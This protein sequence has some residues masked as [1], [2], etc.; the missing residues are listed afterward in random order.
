MTD[1]IFFIDANWN[2]TNVTNQYVFTGTD[3]SN[4]DDGRIG[5]SLAARNRG[6][7]IVLN[8]MVR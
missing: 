5:F 8:L 7:R 2:E 6:E 1:N 3:T 4:K